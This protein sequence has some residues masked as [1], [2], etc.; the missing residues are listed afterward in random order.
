M[1]EEQKRAKNSYTAKMMVP[2]TAHR[3]IKKK[4]HK[5]V[6]A[7]AVFQ[8]LQKALLV[9]G[10]TKREW[11]LNQRLDEISVDGHTLKLQQVPG[12][13]KTDE[14]FKLF[15]EEVRKEYKGH[16]QGRAVASAGRQ[17]AHVQGRGY[18]DER[19]PDSKGPASAS[20]S[21]TGVK[22]P[23]TTE[24][25]VV[26]AF[27]AHSLPNQWK[28]PSKWQPVNRKQ[29]KEPRRAGLPFLTFKEHIT[30][31]PKGY[32]VC[33]GRKQPHDHDNKTGKWYTQGK[34]AFARENPDRKLKSERQHPQGIHE[35]QAELQKL[36]GLM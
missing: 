19:R 11:N 13:M 9:T 24:D 7:N 21:A 12:R 31:Y 1:K 32:F 33:Y 20:V 30:K 25:A 28:D 35:V 17:V 15:G 34:A 6:T 36:M 27:V 2:S 8:R 4:F 3:K 26:D 23:Y 22:D 29:Q 10:D 18:G 16:P 5:T 14:V